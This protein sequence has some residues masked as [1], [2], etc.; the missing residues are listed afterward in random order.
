MCSADRAPRTTPARRP[1]CSPRRGER[2]D[3]E[4]DPQTGDPARRKFVVARAFRV[5]N[6]A[7]CEDLPE[8][9]Y[10]QPGA[11]EVMAE[12]QAMLDGYLAHGGPQLEAR[13]VPTK[14]SH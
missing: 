11:A 1:Y 9:F 13:L 10:P 12:P 6:A 2:D 14:A 4:T 8:R 3:D 7:Q 5:F